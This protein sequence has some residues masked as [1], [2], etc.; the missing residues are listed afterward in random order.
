MGEAED[1]DECSGSEVALLPLILPTDL[2]W[3]FFRHNR[4]QAIGTVP[5]VA[6]VVNGRRGLHE[7]VHD[8]ISN[9]QNLRVGLRRQLYFRTAF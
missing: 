9:R 3:I 8:R 1:G 6:G 7:I 2:S 4:F 5:D